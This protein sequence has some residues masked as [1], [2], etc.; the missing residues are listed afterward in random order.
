MTKQVE[1]K[2]VLAPYMDIMLNVRFSF[3]YSAQ[4]MKYILKEF[5]D[6]AIGWDL[7]NPCISEEMIKEWRKGRVN[8][9]E[10]TIYH[11]FCVWRELA[12]LMGRHGCECN[13]P[14]LPRY[15]PSSFTPYIYSKEEMKRI[16]E[17]SD[18]L[19]NGKN[20]INAALMAIPVILRL[21]YSTGMRVSEATTLKNEDVFL[22]RHYIHLR[23]TKNGHE[24]L[25]PLGDDMIVELRRYETFR[26]R[27]PVNKITGSGNSYFIKLDGIPVRSYSVRLYFRAILDRCDIKF[28]GDKK[29]PR[30]HDLRHT[31]AVHAMLQMVHQGMD[32]YTCLP[33]LSAA[34]GH[35]TLRSTEKYVRLTQAMYPEVAQKSTGMDAF[36]YNVILD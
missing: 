36:I 6:F 23:K 15:K 29:G 11:K 9:S 12:I 33:I 26:N 4:Q 14:R 25:V 1:Y 16:F 3:G 18:K 27:I 24:R 28:V 22:D 19:G 31:F 20:Y 2:S 17:E 30:I 34:L 10:T 32:L 7:R 35:R 21:L 13:I 8:D 5:D